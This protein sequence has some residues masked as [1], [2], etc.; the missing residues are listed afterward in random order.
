MYIVFIK[1]FEIYFKIERISIMS[2]YFASLAAEAERPEFS[3]WKTLLK[4]HAV[5]HESSLFDDSLLKTPYPL[6]T[7]GPGY[8]FAPAFSHWDLIYAL[9]D[10]CPVMPEHTLHQLENML[11]FQQEDGSIAGAIFFVKGTGEPHFY[12]QFPAVWP[13]AVDEYTRV[14]GTDKAMKL[15]FEPLI[16][17]IRWFEKERRAENYGFYYMDTVLPKT[18][19]SG[20]DES[21]RC[22]VV[23]ERGKFPC[24]DA[25]SHVYMLYDAAARWSEKLTGNADEEF[26]AK[27]DELGELIRQKFYSEETG[28]FHDAYLLERGISFRTLT[29]IWP[30][31][32][33]A[34]SPEQANRVIDE[35]LLNPERFFTAHPLPY[36]AI[37]EPYFKLKMWRGGAF[38]SL[39]YMAILG[40]LRYG[41]KDAAVQIAEKILDM[42]LHHYRCT[43]AIWEFY[44]PFG[45]SP[46]KMSRKAAPWLL[47][48]RE[49][50]GHNPFFALARVAIQK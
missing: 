2:M 25:T 28:F 14:T 41:R 9:L 3:R 38:N 48:C 46:M 8:Y 39:T 12:S 33:G 34:A 31:T 1:K 30:L 11:S 6:E 26:V 7:L 16:R 19:E 29:A 44:H 47:P 43:G 45:E 22:E 5:L 35:S 36:V 18:W 42:A 17:Q 21:I 27:R 37:N 49:Y 24:V 15:C 40:C 50:Q 20:V 23:Q 4:H 13:L 10:S 32:C